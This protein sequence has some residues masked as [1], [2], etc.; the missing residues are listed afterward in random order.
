M[1]DQRGK[2]MATVFRRAAGAACLAL[3]LA[4]AV[5][6]QQVKP[7]ARVSQPGVQRMEIFNGPLRSV[8]YVSEGMP[9]T[10]MQT[11]RELER[12]EN[13]AALSD[14]LVALRREY[15]S[16]ERFLENRRAN[17]Q[18]LL[19]GYSSDLGGG[20]YP[21][22][23]IAAYPY[24]SYGY[25]FPY[26]YGSGYGYG[27][28]GGGFWGGGFGTASNSLAFGVGDEGVIKTDMAKT[29]A[30][31]ATPEHAV[32]AARQYDAALA[33]A[34]ESSPIRAA[35]NLPDRGGIR[36]AGVDGGAEGGRLTR[37]GTHVVVTRR[38]GDATDK[39]E[40]DVV[41]E[42]SDWIVLHTPA[43][44]RTISKGTVLDILTPEKK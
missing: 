22:T 43:G 21:G 18:Q 8:H 6:A 9:V 10:E 42:D 37:A 16:N 13:E 27:Y 35:L 38:L 28:G 30:T 39:V 12:A 2:A 19:Y 32:A 17:V 29:L 24:G 4:G 1:L 26:A 5:S 41:R 7:A 15:I 14:Q 23:S 33:R 34:A 25:G 20:F 40:G 31:Q 36:P 3:G 11:L 44:Q